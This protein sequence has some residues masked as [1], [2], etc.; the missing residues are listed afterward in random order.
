MVITIFPLIVPPDLTLFDAAS[1]RASQTF[2]LV[3]F[4]LLIPVT[5]FYNTFG[6]RTFSGK[7][8]SP[9]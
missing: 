5:L 9:S 2:M 8:H 6:F 1:S 4:A 7:I 3:G